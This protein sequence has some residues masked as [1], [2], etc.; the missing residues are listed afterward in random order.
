MKQPVGKWEIFQQMFFWQVSSKP[1]TGS[2]DRL[3]VRHR[4]VK[5]L[6]CEMQT[7][8]SVKYICCVWDE[9]LFTAL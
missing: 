1:L 4:N 8:V 3:L 2:S 6:L 9:F 5:S 7:S